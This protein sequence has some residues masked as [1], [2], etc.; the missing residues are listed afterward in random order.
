M[1]VCM[2]VCSCRRRVDKEHVVLYV[3]WP[4]RAR[5]RL[6]AKI[7]LS[8]HLTT[9]TSPPFYEVACLAE[10]YYYYERGRLIS[11]FLPL[12]SPFPTNSI[13]CNEHRV[14]ILRCVYMCRLHR[15]A[16][17]PWCAHNRFNFFSVRTHY[18]CLT[19]GV[20]VHTTHFILHFHSMFDFS[21]WNGKR[22][23]LKE[24]RK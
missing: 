12:S 10:G 16:Y 11:S 6:P 22:G 20:C 2:Y 23:I 21:R 18:Y 4:R 9:A 14:H 8:A 13:L 5:A 19:V 7:F 3:Q 15:D 24:P 17:S 1:C